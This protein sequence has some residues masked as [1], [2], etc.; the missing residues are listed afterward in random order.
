MIH[1]DS[2]PHRSRSTSIAAAILTALFVVLGGA[3]M[4]QP[5]FQPE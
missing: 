1:N 2:L 5:V 4:G 3:A